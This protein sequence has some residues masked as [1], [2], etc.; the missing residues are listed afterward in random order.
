MKEEARK[1]RCTG[2][3]E[4]KRGRRKKIKKERK[5]TVDHSIVELTSQ[6][7]LFVTHCGRVGRKEGD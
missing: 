4:G 7:H 1:G 5:K 6:R 3:N 2:T